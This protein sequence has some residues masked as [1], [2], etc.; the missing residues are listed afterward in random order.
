MTNYDFLILQP[1]EFECLAR[2]LIQKKER[3]FVESFTIGRDGGIDLRFAKV[4]GQKSIVQVKRYKSLQDLMSELKRE[5]KKVSTMDIDRYILCTS[6]GLTPKNKDEIKALFNPYIVSTEDILGRDDLNNLLGQYPDVEKKYY[7]LWLGSTQVLEAITNN[8]ICNWSDFQLGRIKNDI[9]K[10]VMNDSFNKASSILDENRYVII[11]GIPG[12]GKSTLA[13]M[14]VYRYLAKGYEEFV[15]I[16]GNIDDASQK[17][18]KGRKQIFLFDDFLGSNVFEKGERGFDSKLVSFIE[19]VSKSKDKLFIMTTREYILS[20]AKDEYEKLNIANVDL[21]KCTLDFKYYT[22]GIRAKILYNHL[23]CAGIPREYLS[24]VVKSRR[25]LQIV[26]HKNFNPRIIE[27]IINQRLWENVP[28]Y[29]FFKAIKG[30]F[31]N[32]TAVWEYPFK[33][34]DVYSRHC[35]LVLR[36]LSPRVLIEDWKEAFKAYLEKNYHQ[37]GIMFDED[38]WMYAIKILSDCFISTS[39]QYGEITVSF[40]NPSVPEFLETYLRERKDIQKMLI[41]GVIFEEQVYTVFNDSHISCQLD[42]YMIEACDRCLDNH[43]RCTIVTNVFTDKISK[44]RPDRIWFLKELVTKHTKVFK[45]SGYIE[46]LLSLKDLQAV[47]SFRSIYALVTNVDKARLKIDTDDIIACMLKA[48]KSL[49]AYE[50]MLFYIEEN[51]SVGKYA[52]EIL[53]DLDED[54]SIELDYIS[55]PEGCEDLLELFR[56]LEERYFSPEVFERFYD[57]IN[58]RKRELE[59]KGEEEDDAPDELFDSKDS[60]IEVE[61]EEMFSSLL[62]CLPLNIPQ[63]VAR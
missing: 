24:E 62:Y 16:T 41:G 63:S 45:N 42:D 11:S 25:Y 26:D 46:K 23:A 31:D 7:K 52:E 4:K 17:Y 39:M 20:E 57:S 27:T 8:R 21:R 56:K 13:N 51:S 12:I 37:L 61:M 36:T 33:K 35:L 28:V 22:R 10:Y 55:T 54:L 5:V 53:E 29:D 38:K 2:D 34:L 15:Y 1:N 44:A 6:V 59:D 50:D 48:F 9:H 19:S 49:D 58:S 47:G 60:M 30:M 18:Q 32:P 3:V 43:K 40:H 14:L